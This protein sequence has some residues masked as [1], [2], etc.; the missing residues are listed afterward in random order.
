VTGV[1][2]ID[3][4]SLPDPVA[5]AVKCILESHKRVGKGDP[6]P[7][8]GCWGEAP[9]ESQAPAKEGLKCEVLQQFIDGAGI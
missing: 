2:G 9:V 6:S 3:Y 1:T 7:A 4:A 5:Q 8:K